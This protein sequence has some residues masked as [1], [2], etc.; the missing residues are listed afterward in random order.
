[1][2]NHPEIK[3]IQ[4]V[5]EQK[6]KVNHYEDMKRRGFIMRS[7]ITAKHYEISMTTNKQLEMQI[8]Q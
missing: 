7:E 4:T 5:I 8:M 2:K 3:S 6:Y 1:M